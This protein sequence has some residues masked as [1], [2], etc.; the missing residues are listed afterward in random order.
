METVRPGVLLLLAGLAWAGKGPA[1]SLDRKVDEW[2]RTLQG[3]SEPL[4][5]RLEALKHLAR[6]LDHSDPLRTKVTKAIV[7]TL[8]K[9]PPELVV[10]IFGIFSTKLQDARLIRVL[11]H[12][13][14]PHGKT[15]Q[16]RAAA[17]VSLALG[18][19][20]ASLPTLLHCLGDE[21]PEVVQVV[22]RSL[23]KVCWP[24]KGEENPR[25][26]WRTFVRTE[27][28]SRLLA[29]AFVKLKAVAGQDGAKSAPL[30][31]HVVPLLLDAE[32]PFDAWREG[33]R[34]LRHYVHEEFRPE[35]RRG[36]PVTPAE[37]PRIVVAIRAWRDA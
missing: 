17:V 11:V 7:V 31:A 16:V 34:F 29:A 23:G 10:P 8:V 32:I 5:A 22:E 18:A 3:E 14:H 9:A 4:E 15:R 19:G 36:Q 12:F 24:L 30:V 1:T 6:Q 28:G 26:K 35:E 2:I 37:R 21:D 25:E 13:V 20:I 27:A 33:Y